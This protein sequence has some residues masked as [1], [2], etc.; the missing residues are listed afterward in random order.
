LAIVIMFFAALPARAQNQTPVIPITPAATQEAPA[1]QAPAPEPPKDKTSYAIGAELGRI[2]KEMRLDIAGV[3]PDLDTVTKAL[4]DVVSGAQLQM[5]NDDIK[6]AL[7]DLQKELKT[8]IADKNKADGDKF[9]LE[10]KVA[11]GVITQP[12]GLQYK[13]LKEGT[14]NKP[15]DESSVEVSFTGRFI[16]GKEFVKSQ[17]KS[18]KVGDIAIPGWK[19]ALKLM[20]AGSK[21]ELALKPDLAY[22]AAGNQALS[23]GPNQTVIFEVEIVSVK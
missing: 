16:D 15:T 8:K 19:E 6:M 11:P 3:T 14:G 21:W 18:Y 10:N 17:S 5:S 2:L 9:L 23:I 1:A 22:G 7:L 20:P 13:I 4:R 12:S